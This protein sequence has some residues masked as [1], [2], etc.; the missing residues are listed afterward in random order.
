MP[1]ATKNFENIGKRLKKEGN[2]IC[3][4]QMKIYGQLRGFKRPVSILLQDEL[5]GGGLREL[6]AIET[7]QY[8]MPR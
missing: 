7:N 2:K 1:N 3:K 6:N 8:N 5:D 4:D